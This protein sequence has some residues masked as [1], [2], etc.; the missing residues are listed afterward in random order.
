MRDSVQKVVLQNFI[1]YL[2][3][4]VIEGNVDFKT[5]ISVVDTE[6]EIIIYKIVTVVVQPTRDL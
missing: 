4:N 6:L 5:K 3:L 2:N 1:P